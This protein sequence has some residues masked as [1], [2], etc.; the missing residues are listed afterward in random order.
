MKFDWLQ[1]GIYTQLNFLILTPT[2]D[3]LVIENASFAW[4]ADSMTLKNINLR[5]KN[6]SLVAVVGSVGA[7]KSSLLA[8]VLGELEK[9][10]G[11]INRNVS[12]YG[13]GM[14]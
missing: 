1:L 8:A 11:R 14:V 4:D 3:P 10:A 6:G 9:K 7:G 12:V 13:M 2:E 5:V